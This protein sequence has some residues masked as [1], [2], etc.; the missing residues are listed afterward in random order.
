MKLAEALAIRADLHKDVTA[1]KARILNNAQAKEGGR[2]SENPRK[3]LEKL[4]AAADELQLLVQQI[5]KTNAA[6]E[7]E[8]GLTLADALAVRETLKLKHNVFSGLADAATINYQSVYRADT[9]LQLQGTVEV[10][11][12]RK[13]AHAIARRFRAIDMRIQEKNWQVELQ[14]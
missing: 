5:N 8:P 14:E 12:I 3:L 2:P 10:S 1:L 4:S 9:Q 7:L 6:N 11:D 13:E